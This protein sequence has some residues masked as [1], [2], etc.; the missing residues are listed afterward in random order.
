MIVSLKDLIETGHFGPVNLGMSR[1]QVETSLGAPDDVGGTSRKYR[2][3][4]IWKYGDVELHFVLGGDSLWLI[5][6]D[7][8]DVPSGGKLVEFDPWVIRR[9]L[10]LREAEGYLTRSGIRYEVGDYEPEDDAQH[11]KA[12]AGV[13][14]IFIGE[15]L[16]LRAVSYVND[17]I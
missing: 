13:Q 4:S 15:G 17:S 8:F 3:P 12:G 10:T 2:K 16:A 7:D 5:H 6:L 11:I 1:A 9:S 14:L